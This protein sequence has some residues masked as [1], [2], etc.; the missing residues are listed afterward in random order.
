MNVVQLEKLRHMVEY[1][2]R[3]NHDVD[4]DDVLQDAAAEIVERNLTSI[5]DYRMVVGWHA[6]AAVSASERFKRR[7]TDTY[8]TVAESATTSLY[9]LYASPLYVDDAQRQAVHAVISTLAP[10]QQ[11]LLAAWRQGESY[12][13]IT[14]HFP[15]LTE[16]AVRMRIRKL[17]AKLRQGVQQACKTSSVQCHVM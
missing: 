7:Y 2:V 5:Q 15:T 13:A 17:L 12:R 14:R 16:N 3:H 8:D 10:D 4:V 1:L 9:D 11:E 6:R